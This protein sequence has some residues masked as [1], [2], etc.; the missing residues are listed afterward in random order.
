MA[1][2]IQLMSALLRSRRAGMAG[3]GPHVCLRIAAPAASSVEP[4]ASSRLPCGPIGFSGLFEQWRRAHLACGGAPTTPPYWKVLVGRFTV[5]LGHDHPDAVTAQ[6]IRAYR[7]HLIGSGRRLR[8][9]R[10]SDFAA[11]RALFRFAVENGLLPSD[12]TAG[13]RFRAE[14]LGGGRPMLAFSMEEARAILAA[15]DGQTIAARR[16]IPWLTALT[17]SR[18]AA[19]AN[20]RR[21]DVANINGIWCLRVSRLAGPVKTAASERVVPIHPALLERGFISFVQGLDRTRLFVHE[22]D[23]AVSA[24]HPA[25]STVRHL[26]E[27]LHGLGLGIGRP[28]RKDPNHAW[29]HWFK[30]QAFAAGIPEKITDAIVGHAQATTARRYGSVSVEAMARELEK[31]PG[32]VAWK[33]RRG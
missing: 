15:A 29:R 28:A 10:H 6:D 22:R 12:P 3:P 2:S 1:V 20:L 11:L 14:R 9:A 7:D 25:R 21:E 5:F 13:V 30:E 27:W 24:Y 23:G 26:T 33:G 32:P 17:G 16:W 8:T 31:I 19:I 4:G 18:V